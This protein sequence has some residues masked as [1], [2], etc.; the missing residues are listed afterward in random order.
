MANSRRA[1]SSA[2]H[3]RRIRRIFLRAIRPIDDDADGAEDVPAAA[4]VSALHEHRLVGLAVDGASDACP[5][6]LLGAFG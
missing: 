6:A 1:R 2:S 3:S 4:R 5:S